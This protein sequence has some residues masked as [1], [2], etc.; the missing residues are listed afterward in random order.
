MEKSRY[1]RKETHARDIFIE[2][3]TAIPENFR[4][5]ESNDII[6]NQCKYS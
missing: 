6:G 3:A 4:S 5:N 2:S 1:A